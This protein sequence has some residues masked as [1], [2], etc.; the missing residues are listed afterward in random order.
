[1]RA[2]NFLLSPPIM[3]IISLLLAVIWML[4]DEKDKAR[5]ELVFALVLNLFYGILPQHLHEPRG[6]PSFPGSSITSYFFWIGHSAFRPP[7][8]RG[9]CKALCTFPFG[10]SINRW[11]P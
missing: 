9:L 8:S 5:I 1:M 3:A 2:I 4:R 10:S 7:L 11:F 6:L